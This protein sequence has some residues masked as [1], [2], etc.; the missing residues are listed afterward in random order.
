MCLLVQR[1][2]AVDLAVFLHGLFPCFQE[3]AF[4]GW[5][6]LLTGTIFLL[7]LMERNVLTEQNE[8]GLEEKAVQTS[9]KRLKNLKNAANRIR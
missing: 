5:L 3:G 8:Q 7:T 1:F 6:A 4:W 2:L 9:G